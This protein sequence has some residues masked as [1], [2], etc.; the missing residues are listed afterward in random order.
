[1]YINKLRHK[2]KEPVIKEFFD[3]IETTRKDNE[4]RWDI[5]YIR[6]NYK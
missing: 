1:M 6:G 2:N 4:K 5:K 3:W